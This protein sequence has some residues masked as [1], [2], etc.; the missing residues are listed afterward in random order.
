MTLTLKSLQLKYPNGKLENSYD[1]KETIYDI[2]L[3]YANITKPFLAYSQ[4]GSFE[5]VINL[6]F[7]LNFSSL[8]LIVSLLKIKRKP[9]FTSTFVSKK[10][11]I[12]S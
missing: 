4:S 6:F 11:F 12:Y 8:N 1:I 2:D 9:F 5:S 7:D 10:I 3:N